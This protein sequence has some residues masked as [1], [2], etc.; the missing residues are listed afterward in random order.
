[1][2][3]RLTILYY[4]DTS[5]TKA[6]HQWRELTNRI[7][8]PE[9]DSGNAITASNRPFKYGGGSP[10]LD[11]NINDRFGAQMEMKITLNNSGARHNKNWTGS[12][13]LGQ[14]P[15]A[16]GQISQFNG[17]LPEFTR[18]IVHETIT[19][20][21]LFVGRIYVSQ[22]K[23]EFP[24]GNILRLTCRD[25][26]EEVGQGDLSSGETVIQTTGSSGAGNYPTSISRQLDIIKEIIKQTTYGGGTNEQEISYETHKID[27]GASLIQGFTNKDISDDGKIRFKKWGQTSPL[28]IIQNLANLEKWTSGN[29][30]SFGFGFFLDATRTV[31]YYKITSA[32]NGEGI[33]PQDFTYFRKGHYPTASPEDYGL[34]VTYAQSASVNENPSG[35]SNDRTRNMFNDF[36][37]GGFADS[38]VTHIALIHEGHEEYDRSIESH[39]GNDALADTTW[40]K[41]GGTPGGKPGIDLDKGGS[42]MRW[43][44]S[45]DGSVGVRIKGSLFT[46]EDLFAILYVN[47][48]AG[49]STV[50][51]FSWKVG[52]AA[53]S[54]SDTWRHARSFRQVS[55]L[56]NFDV[57]NQTNVPTYRY[58]GIGGTKTWL[59]NVQ[60]Q[61]V[62]GD[63]NN[64]L[65]L[66]HPQEDVINGVIN[67]AIL[68]ESSTITPRSGCKFDYFPAR[69]R[70]SK[71]VISR[72]GTD[73]GG[74]SNYDIMRNGLAHEFLGANNKKTDR[75]RKGSFRISDWPH[76][77]WTNTAGSGSTGNTLKPFV[78]VNTVSDFGMR[79]GSSV[80][81]T[82]SN[83]V[84]YAGYIYSIDDSAK[85]VTAQ[86]FTESALDEDSTSSLTQKTWSQNDPY[87]IYVS[88]RTGMTIRVDNKLALTIGDHIITS[89]DYT[90]ANGH[91]SSDITTVGINDESLF[92]SR[93]NLKQHPAPNLKDSKEPSVI[94]AM[95]LAANAYEARGIMW[96]HDH[97]YGATPNL[98]S[99][100]GGIGGTSLRDYNSFSWSGGS[101]K[102]HATNN[103]YQIN[104]GN[105]DTQL[106]YSG[107]T[108]PMQANT[109]YVLYLDRDFPN[110][111]ARFDIRIAQ[112]THDD[113]GYQRA[114]SFLEM[115]YLTIGEDEDAGSKT[116]G[117]PGSSYYSVTIPFP[118]G[119]PNIQFMNT[120][121]NVLGVD[122]QIVQADRILQ[123]NSLTSALL[124][125]TLGF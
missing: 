12:E 57:G 116:I 124:K 26:L 77:R 18:I 64:F 84:K 43:G 13:E 60:F 32:I 31:P 112:V 61:G 59:G 78:G 19:Y 82:D 68:F 85:T 125:K 15:L 101:I 28:K 11:C 95:A 44:G 120:F 63:G 92:Q 46:H 69:Q 88:L 71:R 10:I 104:A 27:K 122:N 91:V 8:N 48:L 73:Y 114:P 6:D 66:S 40:N 51:D 55:S 17:L 7:D 29:V 20:M 83:G 111:N 123:P 5:D 50:G 65:I 58:T 56:H 35:S 21:T 100:T 54:G 37:F 2:V 33:L 109:Q 121:S 30:D 87:N 86:M 110:D 41:M 45:Y 72:T 108:S 107:Y 103:F 3:S 62:D 23:F 117:I 106:T 93:E 76:M 9:F 94:D 47:P 53:Y 36:N 70:R 4:D 119:M 34:N 49:N 90:W 38:S 113:D 22:D 39:S 105:T 25:N 75:M 80:T 99:L 42:D 115:A 102:V 52:D 98:A 96:W 24:M 74:G 97:V 79:R 1:M 67:G 14:D 16:N 118:N 89:I 81:S